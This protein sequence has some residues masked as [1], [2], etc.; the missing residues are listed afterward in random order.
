LLQIMLTLFVYVLAKLI[1]LNLLFQSLNA[2][3]LRLCDE[4]KVVGDRLFL[5]FY[6][7]T[8]TIIGC[9]FYKGLELLILGESKQ[10][11]VEFIEDLFIDSISLV[12]VF[13]LNDFDCAVDN[14]HYELCVVFIFSQADLLLLVPIFVILIYNQVFRNVDF[15]TID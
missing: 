6:E 12:L 7:V 8:V 10:L 11:F 14:L 13:S 3:I 15:S 9:Q 2:W 5:F 4:L 1:F